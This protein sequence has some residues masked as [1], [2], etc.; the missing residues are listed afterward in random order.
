MTSN[1]S[2]RPL[3]ARPYG[4]SELQRLAHRYF[5]IALGVSI[6]LHLGILCTYFLVSAFDDSLYPS[7]TGGRVITLTQ[8][9]PPPSIWPVVP[10]VPAPFRKSVIVRNATPVPVSESAASLTTE[11]PTQEELSREGGSSSEGEIGGTDETVV[12]VA[13]PEEGP[14]PPFVPVE[15]LPAVIRSCI[16]LYPEVAARAG[17]EGKVV[18]SVWVDKQGKP[19]EVRVAKSSNDLFNEAALEAAR[20]YLF[21]P[22]YMNAGPVSVWVLLPFTFKLK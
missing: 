11:L 16:P 12:V 22:A 8:L 20:Q 9:P 10:V 18:I 3:A 1:P 4:S 17:I 6:M 19:R 21:T 7:S 15:K 5:I 2:V 14:P 13:P